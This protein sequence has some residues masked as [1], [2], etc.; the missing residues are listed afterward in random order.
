MNQRVVVLAGGTWSFDGT[1]WSILAPSSPPAGSA[2]A[3]DR[4]SQRLMAVNLDQTW[5]LITNTWTV[6]TPATPLPSTFSTG[7]LA[8]DPSRQRVVLQGDRGTFVWNGADW[9]NL[10]PT[11][12]PFEA[13]EAL[14]FD[15][16]RNRLI[17]LTRGGEW[18]LLP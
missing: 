2:L 15:A 1:T 16:A 4:G 5:A 11:T 3:F 7:R 10:Q 14:L 17:A 8:W 6:L 12:Q 18:T 13:P 9:S